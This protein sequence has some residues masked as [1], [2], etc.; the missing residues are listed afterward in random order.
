MKSIGDFRNI[1]R[2]FRTLVNASI[3][4]NLRKRD[5]HST[6]IRLR[7][8][9]IPLTQVWYSINTEFSDF[10]VLPYLLLTNVP[11]ILNLRYPETASGANECN[12]TFFNLIYKL[13]YVGS[14]FAL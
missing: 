14:L 9:R 13:F 4:P 3:S 11:T 6:L 12:R 8:R 7:A 10:A 1:V 5:V 2:I